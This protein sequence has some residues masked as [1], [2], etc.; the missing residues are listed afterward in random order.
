[1]TVIDRNGDGTISYNEFLAWWRT[2]DRFSKIGGRT[3]EDDERLSRA[4]QYFQYFDKDR[5]GEID[6]NEFK[7]LHA[8]LVKNSFTKLSLKDCLAV[9][10]EDGDGH[11]SFNEYINW[12]IRI[13]SLR[14]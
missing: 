9:L 11:V 4:V 5:T 6:G 1:M 13:G 8:D 12:L 7:A 10:D 3:A 2:Q 14:G